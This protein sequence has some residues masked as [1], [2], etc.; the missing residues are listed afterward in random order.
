LKVGQGPCPGPHRQQEG[1]DDLDL[2]M[3]I[4]RRRTVHFTL[5]TGQYRRYTRKHTALE[6]QADCVQ[7][8][9][10][11]DIRNTWQSSTWRYINWYCIFPIHSFSWHHKA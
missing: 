10:H 1:R 3:S 4:I 2:L 6:S 9:R 11:S 8:M 5:L 7:P